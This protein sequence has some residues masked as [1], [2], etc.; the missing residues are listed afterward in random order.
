MFQMQFLGLFTM[1][2][3]LIKTY[4]LPNWVW[5]FPIFF[6][7]ANKGVMWYVGNWKDKKDWIAWET[8]LANK[9]NK[10]F[11]EIRNRARNGESL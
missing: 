3:V 1:W 6:F 11:R 5:P 7:F 2:L 8:E 4:N 10:V 9:R